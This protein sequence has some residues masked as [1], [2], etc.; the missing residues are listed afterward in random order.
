MQ[1]IRGFES[2][3]EGGTST[4]DIGGSVG[5]AEFTSAVLETLVSR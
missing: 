5:T 3:L 1:L 4:P 2:V